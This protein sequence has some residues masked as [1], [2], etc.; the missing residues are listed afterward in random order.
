MHEALARALAREIIRERSFQP[1]RVGE[2][3]HPER[4]PLRR[5]LGREGQNAQEDTADGGGTV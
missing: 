2:R 4:G 5:V 3:R 1:H